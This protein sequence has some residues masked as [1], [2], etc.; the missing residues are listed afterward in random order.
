MLFFV[1]PSP[2]FSGIGVSYG[3]EKSGLRQRNFGEHGFQS[4]LPAERS[5]LVRVAPAVA[6]RIR[7]DRQRRLAVNCRQ[8]SA[9]A[10]DVDTVADS[11][12]CAV[13]PPDSER[14]ESITGTREIF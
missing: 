6:D 11:L 4:E 9:D 13:P 10:N 5:E 8:L 1:F 3:L 2:K 12:K 7:S 14:L